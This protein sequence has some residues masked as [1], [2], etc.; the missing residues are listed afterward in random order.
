MIVI[1]HEAVRVTDPVVSFVD[2]LE[3][4]QEVFAVMVILEDG[5]LFVAA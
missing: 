2:V 5:F 4:V 3:G 1:G